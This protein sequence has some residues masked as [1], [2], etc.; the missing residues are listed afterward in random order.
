[1][2]KILLIN[3]PSNCVDDD[4][5]EPHLGLLYIASVLREKN[6]DVKLYEMTG[7]MTDKAISEKIQDIPASDI[8]GFSVYCTNYNYVKMC[9]DRIRQ[10]DARK[11]K[12]SLIVLGGPNPT[13]I[14]EFTLKDSRCDCVITGEGEDAFLEAAT[15]MQKGVEVPSLLRGKGRED[16]DSYP[17]P[18]WDLVNLRSYS[19]VLNGQKAV[20]LISSRGCSH[21]CAHCNSIVMG[22]GSRNIRYRKPKKVAEEIEHLIRIG[23]TKFRFNDDNFTGNPNLTMLLSE[24]GKLSI[25][26]RAFGRIDDLTEQ[27]CH[28][29]ARSGC[30]HLSIGL[31][32][33][34]PDNLRI[35]GKY[36]QSGLEE[37]NLKN[38]K[39]FG[40][41]L[42][43]YFIVGLPYDD[44]QTIKKYFDIAKDLPFDEYSIYPLIPYPGT[45]IAERPHDFGYEIIDLDFTHYIQ[46]GK[47][48][49]TTFALRHKN[50][51]ENDVRRWYYY[52]EELFR[53][54]SKVRQNESK[55]A[56]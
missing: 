28:M 18:A 24:I 54:S 1:M 39:K 20:S 35:L 32:S 2:I 30:K 11:N 52:V 13:A 8:Y 19:R 55:I 46:I 41:A 29:L 34:N 22:A 3:P 38:A 43:V 9:I 23:I 31:E 44:D 37:V 48:R 10:I 40:I 16:I 56:L 7:C 47:N 15:A 42:R 26:F 4:R 5:L 33:L 45:A 50:F 17:M 14:P 25:Q 36:S 6:F 21:N 49:S 51:S 53:S 12:K 27:N